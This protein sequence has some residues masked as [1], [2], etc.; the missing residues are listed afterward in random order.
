MFRVV[1]DNEH[2]VLV[3]K[4]PGIGFHGDDDS[5]GLLASVKESLQ[6]PALY[7]VHR[8]DKMT[9]G[10]V[11]MAKTREANRELSMA[12]EARAVEKYY[13]AL[14]RK[15]PKKKQG[16]IKG[17]MERGRRG[18][19]KLMPSQTNPAVTQFFSTGLGDGLR[20]FLLKPH[21]GKTH[22][23]RVAL[24]S[25]G[26]PILGDPTYGEGAIAGQGSEASVQADGVDRGYLHAY[27]LGFSL[28]GKDY[29]FLS[30][31][32]QGAYFKAESTQGL[33]TGNAD[34]ATPWTLPWPAVKAKAAGVKS[35]ES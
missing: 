30:L 23:L 1:E 4:F 35:N 33:L 17:D 15:K 20:L 27:C 2:F 16:L 3:D 34:W 10:L 28:L 29:R 32:N 21:T 6:L 7:P 14:S 25:I 12:F 22:Q 26:A 31:P 19:W 13:L 5:P 24:K 9:S 8:L 18:S 11:V